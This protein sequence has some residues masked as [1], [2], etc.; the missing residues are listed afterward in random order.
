MYL[1]TPRK[2]KKRSKL[3]EHMRI[4]KIH[5]WQ[6]LN[7]ARLEELSAM[8]EQLCDMVTKK[9]LYARIDRPNSIV[10]FAAPKTPDALLNDWSNPCIAAL[11]VLLQDNNYSTNG[12][13]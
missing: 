9:Q 7:T 8:E 11:H 4:P 12:F 13:P 2:L 3:P 6:F 1:W 5:E 10:N